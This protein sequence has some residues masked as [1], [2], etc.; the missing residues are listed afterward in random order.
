MKNLFTLALCLVAVLSSQAQKDTLATKYAETI[1]ADELRSH[2]EVL[3]SD[4]YEGRETG[5]KGQKMAAKYIN[6]YFN[7]LGLD[8]RIQEFPLRTEQT[9][10]ATLTLDGQSYSFYDEF[11]FFPGF[12]ET[13]FNGDIIFA[14]YG[15][16]SESYNDYENLNVTGKIVVALPG[17]P[18]DKAGNYRVTGSDE[19]SEWSGDWRLKRT[20]AQEMGAKALI[21]L[22][23]DYDRYI[24]RIKYYLENPGMRLDMERTEKEEVLPTFFISKPILDAMLGG[25]KKRKKLMKKMV[26]KGNALNRSLD[27][28]IN[29]KIN[30]E[31]K[32]FTSENVYAVIE[33]TDPAL[34]D[35]VV[36]VTAHYDHVGAK[37]G[38]VY[39]GADDD[40]SG[41]VTVLEIAQAFQKAKDE[42]NGTKRSVLVMTVSG[43]EKGLLGSEW[44]V[45]HP[46]FPLE[47]AVANL[48]VDMIGRVDEQHADDENY[49][50]LIGSDKLSTE[51][52]AI[53]E[54]M[55]STYV[56]LSLDYTYNHPDDPNRFYYRSDHYN[57]AKNN[58]PVIF[59]FSG[60]HEDYHQPTDTPDKIMYDKTAKIGKLIFHTAWELANRPE[61]IKV[62]VVNDFE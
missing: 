48:N 8:G 26:K 37:D 51:L 36:V 25:E 43:E 4:A 2:L 19:M 14:G 1:T 30:R 20:L 42:G 18:K 53:S 3:A 50:Y 12:D 7:G 9:M 40:G 41:T 56:N 13:A 62:D 35:E 28:S 58:I 29:I 27:K 22:N 24:G 52:H 61:R 23:E 57:F 15:V 21:V 47:N 60:V 33:G 34:K 32:N 46:T 59:Y 11:Y 31:Q 39:N 49:I 6:S 5:K 44:F 54:N 16:K 17:E 10:Q 55:N 45:T 38:E